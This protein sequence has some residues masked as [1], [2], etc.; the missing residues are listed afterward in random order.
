[1]WRSGP[2]TSCGY[3]H[4]AV[5]VGSRETVDAVAEQLRRDGVAIRS[6]PRLTGDGYDEA[7]VEDPDGNGI[8]ISV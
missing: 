1:M 5:S 2:S 8:E 3:A 4:L 7:V 6:A